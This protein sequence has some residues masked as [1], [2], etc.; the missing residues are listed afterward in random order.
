MD[1]QEWIALDCPACG[2]RLRAQRSAIGTTVG[3][4]TC[5]AAVKVRAPGGFGAPSGP[6]IIDSSR[7]LGV[8]PELDDRETEAFKSRLRSSSD[9]NYKVDPD[10]PVMK[11]RDTRKAKHGAVLTG[12]D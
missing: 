11:R 8:S 5:H 4:P 9:D 3:C 12:W 6:M 10:N 7:K 2:G 1:Q